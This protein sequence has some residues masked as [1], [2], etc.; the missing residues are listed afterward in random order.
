MDESDEERDADD[1]EVFQHPPCVGW[2]GFGEGSSLINLFPYVLLLTARNG[3]FKAATKCYEG[4][5]SLD[6]A[7]G[8]YFSDD[9]SKSKQST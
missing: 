4:A 1:V 9:R 2:I 6:G 5:C 3:T 8:L 7:V